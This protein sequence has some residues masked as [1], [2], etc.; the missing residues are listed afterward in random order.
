[1]CGILTN[2]YSSIE[3][4]DYLLRT[5]QFRRQEAFQGLRHI[6]G[7]QASIKEFLHDKVSVLGTRVPVVSV[8]A[9]YCNAKI[10]KVGTTLL[11]GA[12]SGHLS[13]ATKNTSP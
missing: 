4:F 10:F 13:E 3:L 12:K 1:M 11:K 8:A 9:V 7:S 6:R 5:P 2:T